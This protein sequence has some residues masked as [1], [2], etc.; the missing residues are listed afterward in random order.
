LSAVRAQHQSV[1]TP[2]KGL[3]SINGA[4]KL[5]RCS[6]PQ[7]RCH[8]AH[9]LSA[10][11]W[12]LE[13]R[14]CVRKQ[15]GQHVRVLQVGIIFLLRVEW[16]ISIARDIGSLVGVLIQLDSVQATTIALYTLNF[17]NATQATHGFPR[18]MHSHSIR[19]A[20]VIACI[21]TRR[22]TICYNFAS[23]F[24]FQGSQALQS[25]PHTSKKRMLLR[26][27]SS[28]L[29]LQ[30]CS[31]LRSPSDRLPPLRCS[32]TVTVLYASP[33]NPDIGSQHPLT[34]A[35]EFCLLACS[36]IASGPFWQSLIKTYRF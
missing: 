30:C 28:M 10:Q 11:R 12:Q 17:D 24:K 14:D 2:M 34:V 25:S 27:N 13:Q 29:L 26:H 7:T 33:Q 19:Y 8:T 16:C 15:A 4:C 3:P 6:R 23:C 21:A 22:P 36:T 31:R 35:F 32:A 9:G 20:L 5:L 1:P 18:D